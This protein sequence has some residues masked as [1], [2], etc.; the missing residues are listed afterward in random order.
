MVEKREDKLYCLKCE[1]R[2]YLKVSSDDKLNDTIWNI[3][4]LVKC[5]DCIKGIYHL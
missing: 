5:T 2:G 4:F 3:G 1:G